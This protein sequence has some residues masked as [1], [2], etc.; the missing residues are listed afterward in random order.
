MELKVL[1]GYMNLCRYYHWT[2]TWDGLK[3]FARGDRNRIFGGAE[4]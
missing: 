2:P 1:Q 3:A 4:K